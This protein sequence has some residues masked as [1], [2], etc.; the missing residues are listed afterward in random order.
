M[1][2]TDLRAQSSAYPIG[3]RTVEGRNKRLR[4]LLGGREIIVAPGCFD[5]LSARLVEEAG[6]SAAYITGS[7]VSIS[8]LG[9]PDV[10]L[11]SFSEVLDRV[12][13]IADAVTIPLIADIDTGFGGPLNI[14][15]T[16]REFERAGVSAVQIEDQQAPKKCGHELGRR[17]VE[18]AEMTSRIKAAVD[19][20]CDADF[21]IVARTDARTSLGLEAALERADA[22]LAAGADILFIESPED[23]AEMRTLCDHLRGRAPTLANMVEG[24]RTPILPAAQLEEIGFKVVIFPNALTRAFAHAGQALLAELSTTGTT[25]GFRDRMFDHD[26]LWSLFDYQTWLDLE[27]DFGVPTNE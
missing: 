1:A 12:K 3:L 21:L 18:T 4:S 25:T 9:A 6:F 26:A 19:A 14:I 24:G 7:G 5:C 22:Y 10:N 23:E 2:G 15:R 11:A 20:R 13:R 8:Q 16:V 27:R 17:V